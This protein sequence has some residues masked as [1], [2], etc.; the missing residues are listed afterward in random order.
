MQAAAVPPE[1][2]PELKT[3][4]LTVVFQP[5]FWCLKLLVNHRQFPRRAPAFRQALAPALN[6]PEM[7]AQTRRDH[8]ALPPHPPPNPHNA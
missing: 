7:V 8:S 5:H 3:Q 1:A 6:L 2:D 4:G